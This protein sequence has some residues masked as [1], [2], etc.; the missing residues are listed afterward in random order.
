MKISYKIPAIIGTSFLL[1][2]IIITASIMGKQGDANDKANIA[3]RI[4]LIAGCGI[5]LW[6]VMLKKKSKEV[7]K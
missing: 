7:S 4:L 6:A 1:A 2:A 3:S 5:N